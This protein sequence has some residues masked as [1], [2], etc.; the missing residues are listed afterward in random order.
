MEEQANWNKKNT[1]LF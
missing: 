1:S